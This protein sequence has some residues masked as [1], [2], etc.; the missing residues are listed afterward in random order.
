MT[1]YDELVK[2]RVFGLPDIQAITGNEKTANSML[3][4]LRAKDLVRKI[5]RSMYSCVNPATGETVASRY[6]IAC[7]TSSGA[8]LSHYTAFEFHGVANQVYY[9]MYVGSKSRFKDFQFEGITYKR[10]A[11][12]IDIGVSVPR[13][14]AGIRVTDLERTVVD[15]IND[16]EKIGGFGELITCL[17]AI[18]YLDEEK[19]KVYLDAYGTQV[20]YQKTGFLLEHFMQELQLSQAFIEYCRKQTGRSTRYLSRDSM[21]DGVYNNEWRL[22]VPQGLFDV[23]AQ[24]DGELV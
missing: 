15:S 16:F 7:A 3:A 18:H 6:Q 1:G 22:V 14:S 13:N 17:S 8:Y 12:K 11:P 4:R 24:G 10:I 20:L 5:K 9:E 23:N 19:L 21:N 2:L